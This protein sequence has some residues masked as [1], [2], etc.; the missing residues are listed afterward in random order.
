MYD[1]GLQRR[2][3]QELDGLHVDLPLLAEAERFVHGL[4]QHGMVQHGL[5]GGERKVSG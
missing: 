1:P 5:D 4:G 3:L 2:R